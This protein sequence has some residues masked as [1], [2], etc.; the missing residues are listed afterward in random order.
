MVRQRPPRH[1]WPT[2]A[3]ICLLPSCGLSTTGTGIDVDA[4]TISPDGDA[5]TVPRGGGTSDGGSAGDDGGAAFCTPLGPGAVVQAYDLSKLTVKGDAAWNAGGDGQLT[6]T[7][8]ANGK[9]GAA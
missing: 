7:P 5:S 6:L 4:S 8:Q 3:L 2:A 9:M 1:A